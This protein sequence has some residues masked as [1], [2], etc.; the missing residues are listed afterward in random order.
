MRRAA[1]PVPLHAS[2]TSARA[3]ATAACAAPSTLTS[4]LAHGL[5]VEHAD[6]A[7][8][9][10][11]DA[12]LR[13]A[14]RT[15]TCAPPARR[16][17]PGEP[18]RPRR[19]RARLPPHSSPSTIG[20]TQ[21]RASQAAQRALHHGEECRGRT[22][23]VVVSGIQD[24]LG[25]RLV[26]AP[27]VGRG[28]TDKMPDGGGRRRESTVSLGALACPNEAEHRDRRRVRPSAHRYAGIEGSPSI[29][30][31]RS[32]TRSTTCGAPSC[33]HVLSV[34]RR[35][36]CPKE[37]FPAPCSS[38]ISSAC[39]RARDGRCRR[40]VERADE[41]PVGELEAHPDNARRPIEA[42]RMCVVEYDAGHQRAVAEATIHPAT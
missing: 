22:L 1:G 39:A 25:C 21:W 18:S 4:R 19:R 7:L 42:S 16:G 36:G 27:V 32:C 37:Q 10:R 17:A 24:L 30:S 31:Q 6:V 9:D 28:A 15:D 5:L 29:S 13:V 23:R 2:S 8:G 3:R 26:R 33:I 11:A 41:P 12:V 40:R 35:P 34:Y 20:S 38:A 14:R